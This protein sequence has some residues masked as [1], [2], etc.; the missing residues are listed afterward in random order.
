MPWLCAAQW[1]GTAARIGTFAFIGALFAAYATVVVNAP[2][3]CVLIVFILAPAWLVLSA[4]ALVARNYAAR[5]WPSGRAEP[6]R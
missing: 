1:G 4:V 6:S 5:R 2:G 3:Q